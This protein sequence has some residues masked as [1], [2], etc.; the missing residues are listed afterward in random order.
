MPTTSWL[1]TPVGLSTTHTPCV[2]AFALRL[3]IRRAGGVALA[4]LAQDVV[5][6]FRRAQRDVGPEVEDRRLLGADLVGDRTLKSD[7]MAVQGLDDLGIA[8]FALQRV[9]ID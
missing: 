7:A 1:V 2:V 3:G 6:A 4:I 8:G 5:D 9:E